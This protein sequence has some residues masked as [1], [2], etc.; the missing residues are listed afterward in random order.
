MLNELFRSSDLFTE[1]NDQ[2]KSINVECAPTLASLSWSKQDDRRL[3]ELVSRLGEN[4]WNL[5]G[6]RLIRPSSQCRERYFSCLRPQLLRSHTEEAAGEI[7]HARTK[8][9]QPDRLWC[10]TGEATN[11][12]LYP[13]YVTNWKGVAE[14]LPL[15]NNSAAV[16]HSQNAAETRH[17]YEQLSNRHRPTSPVRDKENCPL[18]G[19]GVRN[20]H[21]SQINAVKRKSAF[22]EVQDNHESNRCKQ[23]SVVSL[24]L[25]SLGVGAI[26]KTNT[27]VYKPEPFDETQS[28]VNYISMPLLNQLSLKQP[29]N[30]DR[31]TI[32]LPCVPESSGAIL[33][34]RPVLRKAG[35]LS[36]VIRKNRPTYKLKFTTPWSQRLVLQS[37]LGENSPSIGS[38]ES[39]LRGKTSFFSSAGP[40]TGLATGMIMDDLFSVQTPTKALSEADHLSFHLSSPPAVLRNLVT[41]SGSARYMGRTQKSYGDQTS[42]RS[43]CTFLSSKVVERKPVCARLFDAPSNCA[44]GTQDASGVCSSSVPT[45]STSRSLISTSLGSLRPA[46]DDAKCLAVLTAKATVWSK[47]L[48]P[49]TSVVSSMPASTSTHIK[50]F[51]NLPVSSPEF[52][53]PAL[54]TDRSR[55]FGTAH[56]SPCKSLPPRPQIPPRQQP[57]LSSR[58]VVQIGFEDKWRRF[59]LG[60]SKAHRMTIR[61]ARQ[62]LDDFKV[63]D[64]QLSKQIEVATNSPPHCNRLDSLLNVK[65]EPVDF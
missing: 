25:D 56:I 17:Q 46:S 44:S 51:E 55:V 9:I 57:Q 34:S 14:E 28:K 36:S 4:R 13:V 65:P 63:F 6:K 40:V 20:S 42:A 24:T 18:S 38:K 11:S 1:F 47:A 31:L 45:Q 5:I 59:A 15:T 29:A 41:G 8:V 7:K 3:L 10:E 12:E 33:T 26:Q 27:R 60:T 64:S 61:M 48:N 54:V 22:H 30:P 16:S 58:R 62:F 53:F 43:Y 19:V 35:A 50:A 37:A 32:N 39:N 52:V 49:V 23:K 2:V 21:F